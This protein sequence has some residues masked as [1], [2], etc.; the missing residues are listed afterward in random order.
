[1]RF[2]KGKCG[3]HNQDSGHHNSSGVRCRRVCGGMIWSSE[4]RMWVYKGGVSHRAED[5]EVTL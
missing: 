3:W 4:L 1:M 2:E 5:V